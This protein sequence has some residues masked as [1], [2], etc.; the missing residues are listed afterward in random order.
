MSILVSRSDGMIGVRELIGPTE[1]DITQFRILRGKDFLAYRLVRSNRCEALL[2]LAMP[3][4]DD[5]LI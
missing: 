2:V 4:F 3:L 5:R 1:S